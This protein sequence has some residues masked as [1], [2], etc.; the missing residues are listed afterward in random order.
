MVTD[1]L[2]GHSITRK[3]AAA[4]NTTVDVWWARHADGSDMPQALIG[5][6]Y[7]Q[8]G[9]G[10]GYYAMY[11]VCSTSSGASNFTFSEVTTRTRG[12]NPVS[13]IQIAADGSSGAVKL[14]VTYADQDIFS[15][16]MNAFVTFIGQCG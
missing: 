8:I 15:G 10:N 4:R 5:R 2:G 6:F 13:S 3:T 9:G 16:G 1:I 11:D 12:T 14:T 7:I